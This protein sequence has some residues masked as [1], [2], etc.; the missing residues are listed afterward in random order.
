MQYPVFADILKQIDSEC[1]EATVSLLKSKLTA[2]ISCN[3][4]PIESPDSLSSRLAG[5]PCLPVD[6][7]HPCD[8]SGKPMLFIAQINFAELASFDFQ[9]AERGLLMLFWNAARR[10]DNA[11]DRHAFSCI[12]IPEPQS[13]TFVQ[14]GFVESAL[15]PAVKLKFSPGWSLPE[16]ESAWQ[17]SGLEAHI[18][19][20][21]AWR[22]NQDRHMQLL[23]Q[24]GKKFDSLQEVAAFAGNGVTW[25]PTRRSDPCFNHLINNACDWKL[26]MQIASIPEAGLDLS[27]LSIYLLITKE[28]LAKHNYGS[29]WLL[30]A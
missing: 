9:L 23:G 28:N 12:W 5:I 20:Q 13:L 18:A 4:E 30:L 6:I 8:C 24:A 19:S 3:V 2:C 17:D 10:Y 26:F 7:A 22:L 16:H 1:S 14:S 11:K 29:S 25:S 21:V 15:G 27:G